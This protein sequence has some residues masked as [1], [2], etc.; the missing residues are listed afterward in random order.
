MNGS[1]LARAV[2]SFSIS[3][4]RFPSHRD[5]AGGQEL[6]D[7]PRGYG[8]Y[9]GLSRASVRAYAHRWAKRPSRV[10]ERPSRFTLRRSWVSDSRRFQ[11]PSCLLSATWSLAS[12]G[13]V[14]RLTHGA[15]RRIRQELLTAQECGHVF[16]DV[17]LQEW[18]KSKVWC[19][20]DMLHRSDCDLCSP[21]LLGRTTKP[22]ARPVSTAVLQPHPPRVAL[23]TDRAAAIGTCPA[24]N[25]SMSEGRVSA[26]ATARAPAALCPRWH[27]PCWTSSA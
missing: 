11:Q 12:S 13:L 23:T 10:L 15:P 20:S 6:L 4:R 16:H 2:K 19:R 1:R 25:A 5:A 17:C 26:A 7:L 14:A 22:P 8:S 3:W 24:R 9:R 18:A 27:R 21:T